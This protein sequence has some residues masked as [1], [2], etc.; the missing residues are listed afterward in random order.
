MRPENQRIKSKRAAV[1]RGRMYLKANLNWLSGFPVGRGE[2]FVDWVSVPKSGKIAV[3][4]VRLTGEHLHSATYTYN[5]LIYNFPQALSGIVENKELWIGRVPRLLDVLK[6][7]VNKNLDFPSSFV[8]VADSFPLKIVKKSNKLIRQVKELVPVVNAMSWLT[9]IYPDEFSNALEWL[10]SHQ[11]IAINIMSGSTKYDGIIIV[12]L[13]FQLYKK[14]GKNKVAGISA[15]LSDSS[16]FGIVVHGTDSFLDKLILF[17]NRIK[18]GKKHSGP[19]EMPKPD[20]G[21]KIIEFIWWLAAQDQSTRRRALNLFSVLLPETFV[22]SRKMW[23]EDANPLIEKSGRILTVNHPVSIKESAKEIGLELKVIKEKIPAL[24]NTGMFFNKIKKCSDSS[25]KDF[26]KKCLP[27]LKKLPVEENDCLA[28]IEFLNYFIKLNKYYSN[29]IAILPHF[30]LYLSKFSNTDGILK[31]WY[32]DVL[33]M[34]SGWGV[35]EYT[36]SEIKDQSL[37]PLVFETLAQIVPYSDKFDYEDS[38]LLVSLVKITRS[39]SVSTSYIK[40]LIDADKQGE[41]FSEEHLKCIYLL[42]NGTENV[43]FVSEN[44]SRLD[45]DDNE[46]FS[47]LI[48]IVNELKAAGWDKIPLQIIKDGNLKLLNALGLKFA[49]LKKMNIEIFPAICPAK[50]ETPE[51]GKRYPEE[52]LPEI[53]I[54]EHISVNFEKSADAEKKVYKIL[55]DFFPDREKIINEIETI[56][57]QISLKPDNLKL[58]TRLNN[59]KKRLDGNTGNVSAKRLTKLRDKLKRAIRTIVVQGWAERMSGTLVYEYEKYFNSTVPSN[60]FNDP[61]NSEV[62]SGIINLPK[63]FRD[64][65]FMLINRKL[66]G[67]K[68]S[69]DDHTE[70]AKFIETIEKKGIKTKYWLSPPAPYQH[71]GKEGQSV[72]ISFENDPLEIIKMGHYFRTCLSPGSFNFFSAIANAADINK[73]VVYARDKNGKVIGRCLFALTKEGRILTFNPYCHDKSLEFDKIM[74]QLAGNLAEQ[75]NT[76]VASDG[77]VPCLVVNDW[78]DDGSINLSTRFSFLHYKSDFRNSLFTI[79]LDEF[80]PTLEKL[81]SPYPLDALTLPLIIEF[82]EF[83]KRPELILPL[84]PLIMACDGDSGNYNLSRTFEESFIIKIAM[85]AYLAEE[86]TFSVHILK[87]RA[88]KYLLQERKYRWELDYTLLKVLVEINPS[89]ALRVLR[90]TRE[91]GIKADKDETLHERIQLLSR[92]HEQMGRKHIADELL[93]KTIAGDASRC[94]AIY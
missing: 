62:L 69:L 48:L 14:D 94:N 61:T 11:K 49:T 36:L 41:Y 68:T 9:F 79:E 4:R 89:A 47:G 45:I 46:E 44:M 42:D 17:V 20:F 10:D 77:E 29:G 75:M 58:N 13:L 33:K 53:S 87:K 1:S 74:G 64:I 85:F 72:T 38:D 76:V 84:L 51:W 15:C 86:K 83:Q 91:K 5:K 12:V 43:G 57:K 21:S 19:P 34:K 50:P 81:F 40:Q 30:K 28:G 6:K 92:V 52:L 35:F 22:E 31:P 66:K 60:F 55:S 80:V 18:K 16:V 7:S 73:H 56:K 25:M 23:W 67:E 93:K 2:G 71:E 65:G 54:L 39:L 8:D 90:K 63:S 37:W 24:L 82:D 26:Y 78:Y 3:E 32:E 27:V 59:L 70:N 88:E